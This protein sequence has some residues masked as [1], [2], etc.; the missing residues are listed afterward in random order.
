M[1]AS[2]AR[3]ACSW[4]RRQVAAEQPLPKNE[5]QT[6][7]D[8]VPRDQDGAGTPP[9]AVVTRTPSTA[10]QIRPQPRPRPL[11]DH[12]HT[13][14][15]GLRPTIGPV[16]IA[17]LSGA[18][19]LPA[20]SLHLPSRA[21]G[22]AVSSG[23]GPVTAARATAIS[24]TPSSKAACVRGPRDLGKQARATEDGDV[25]DAVDG[26]SRG[27]IRRRTSYEELPPPP[28][29]RQW[30]SFTRVG[31]RRLLRY[32]SNGPASGT[33]IG[34]GVWGPGECLPR[35]AKSL[36]LRRSRGKPPDARGDTPRRR[37]AQLPTHAVRRRSRQGEQA[38]AGGRSCPRG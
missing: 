28:H 20:H 35:R 17:E 33:V 13:G 34:S 2:R 10:Q 22:C 5:T 18:V 8:G 24:A 16:D 26:P 37:D 31:R 23:S 3:R 12:R 36:D 27:G 25:A 1:A 15:D 4:P 32:R 29:P 7:L 19:R 6:G 38:Q 21:R 9:R 30:M 14:A 11:R